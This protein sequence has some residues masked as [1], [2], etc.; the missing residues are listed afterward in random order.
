MSN[1]PLSLSTINNSTD[2]VTAIFFAL[3]G[4]KFILRIDH[5][6]SSSFA[7]VLDSTGNV[8]GSAN[9]MYSDGGW[10]VHTVPFAGY[11]S[12]SQIVF[13]DPFVNEVPCWMVCDEN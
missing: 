8:I 12:P 6:F 11:V 9:Q 7:D 1:T 2:S 5:D 13:V 3:L 10:A 4:G